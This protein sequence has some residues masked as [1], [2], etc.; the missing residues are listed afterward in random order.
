[1]QDED[2]QGISPD[3][4]QYVEDLGLIETRPQVRISNRIYREVIPR[5]LTW[6]MQTRI[7]N[8]EQEWYVTSKGHL[9]MPK[10]L[11]AFQQFF[12]E[13]AD[14]W[15]ERFD[16]KEAGPQLLMQAF[17][18][19][20][21]NGGGRISREYG[22]GRKRTDLFIEWP[23]DPARGFHGPMQRIVIELKLQ[24]G[25]LEGVIS[26]GLVQTAAYA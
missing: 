19:R 7:P 12:R 26:Q 13:Q 16:Y 3:D 11:R 1:G 14:A 17:L 18:Q 15:L 25:A 2:L 6:I 24:R 8:Q 21:V 5:D 9:D 4:Q 22:L 10:L 23:T 20:I